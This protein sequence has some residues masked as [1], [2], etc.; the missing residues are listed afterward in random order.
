MIN[1][2]DLILLLQE[3]LKIRLTYKKRDKENN[4]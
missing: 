2:Y 1:N 4:E 3:S